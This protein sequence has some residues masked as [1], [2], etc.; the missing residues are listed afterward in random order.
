MLRDRRHRREV[1]VAQTGH[2][3][4]LRFRRDQARRVRGS[5]R[6]QREVL[7]AR[8]PRSPL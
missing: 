6:A 8:L 2:E 4:G 1:D 5:E 7:M 3:L